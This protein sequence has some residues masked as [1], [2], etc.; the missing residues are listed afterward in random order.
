[1]PRR[2]SATTA[3][4]TLERQASTDSQLDDDE[5]WRDQSIPDFSDGPKTHEQTLED[6]DARGERLNG[7][8]PTE[9]AANHV[10]LTNLELPGTPAPVSDDTA[11]PTETQ[12]AGKDF[13]AA[14][15]LKAVGERLI[16]EHESLADLSGVEI[17]YLW[18][19]RGGSSGGNPKLGALQ[20]PGGL[21]RYFTGGV[22]FI[23]WLAADNVR[24]LQLDPAKIEA[25]LF[26]QLSHAQLNP[27]DDDAWR[28]RSHDFEGFVSELD[29][30]G[31]W[32]ADLRE[33]AAHIRLLPLDQALA[34]TEGDGEADEGEESE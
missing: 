15:G 5:S 17:R 23:C 25:C 19:R 27:D 10:E 32:S 34:D 26:H 31:A 12:F 22:T 7:Y 33:V 30:Y 9:G 2:S 16:F 18:K 6:L 21:L 29:Q 24:A 14:P 8:K 3:E 4:S 11:I 13:L 20:R 1:M 28:I